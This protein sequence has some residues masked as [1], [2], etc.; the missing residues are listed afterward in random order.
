MSTGS[1][2]GVCTGKVMYVQLVVMCIQ[3]LCAA[4]SKVCT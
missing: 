2:D 1:S 4:N 3:I